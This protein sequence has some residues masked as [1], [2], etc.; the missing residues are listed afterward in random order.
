MQI[1]IGI[2]INLLVLETSPEAF[3]KDVIDPP[4]FTIHTDADTVLLEH[5]GKRLSSELCALVGIE[6]LGRA[7]SSNS[8]G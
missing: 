6:D 4:A 3:D 2:K 7:V 8:L 1:A 5:V